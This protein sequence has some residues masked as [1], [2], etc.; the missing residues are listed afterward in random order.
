M[1]NK[2]KVWLMLA[3]ALIIIVGLFGGGFALGILQSF[4]Y[5]PLIGQ[6]D[7][8]LDAY[9]AILS[10]KDFLVSLFYTLYISLAATLVSVILA[11]ILS[12]GIREAFRGKSFTLFAYQF[13]LPI[14]HL[15]SG[16]AMLLMF[17]QS[18]F[19]SRLLNSAGLMTN[20]ADFPQIIYG[21]SGLGIILALA[22]KFTP[23]VGIAILAILQ[24]T[25]TQYEE[26]AI[27]LGASK[28]KRF[29]YVLFPIM[30][31][32]I[33]TSAILCFAYA[34]SSYEVPFL[35]GSVYPKTLA[36]TAYEKFSD[37]DIS[38][39]P[40]AM[41]MAVIITIVVM[42]IVIAYRKLISRYRY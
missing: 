19:V 18:G 10:N 33:S 17:T 15:V 25:G 26:A 14:P 27:S 2:K 22:W 40:Q 35:L 11:I 34:F 20:P 5:M 16:I 9:A 23:F 12:M 37:I 31:P 38:V 32:S 8:N 21:R 6:Y 30:I 3:P 42:A 7:F 24:T 41:A 28:W 29:W 36:I 4:N 39:R 13:P 1:G